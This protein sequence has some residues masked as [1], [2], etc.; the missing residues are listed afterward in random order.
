MRLWHVDVMLVVLIRV[1]FSV[2]GVQGSVRPAGVARDLR[3]E[4]GAGCVF[5]YAAAPLSRSGAL[6]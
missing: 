1:F 4:G 6:G 5:V 2:D 3:D